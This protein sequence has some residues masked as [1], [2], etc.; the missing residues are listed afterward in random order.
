[1]GK[2]CRL[3]ENGLTC[4]SVFALDA[5]AW[6]VSQMRL[7]ISS[8]PVAVLISYNINITVCGD[9]NGKSNL[10]SDKRTGQ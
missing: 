5:M 3:C 1:M 4:G 9:L 2:F 8:D 6:Q 7:C 10:S